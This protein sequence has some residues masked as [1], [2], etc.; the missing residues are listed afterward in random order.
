M[1]ELSLCYPNNAGMLAKRKATGYAGQLSDSSGIAYQPIAYT[2]PPFP[3]NLVDSVYCSRDVA[4]GK[5]T[6][7]FAS[8]GDLTTPQASD[9]GAITDR[10]PALVTFNQKV[11]AFAGFLANCSGKVVQANPLTADGFEIVNFA[12]AGIGN[13][14]ARPAVAC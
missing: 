4:A 3:G 2:I 7:L 11:Y 8:R 9:F 10:R 5:N 6:T 14:L 1:P 12:F 13:A